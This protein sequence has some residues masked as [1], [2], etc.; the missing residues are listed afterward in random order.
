MISR[1]YW[2][3]RKQF[4]LRMVLCDVPLWSIPK[5]TVFGHPYGITI[6]DNTKMGENCKFRSNVTIG[7]KHQDDNGAVIG[8]N[9]NFGAGCIVLGP[10]KIGDNVTIAAGAIVTNNI[11]SNTIFLNRLFTE[12]RTTQGSRDP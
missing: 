8:N 11:P 9:V 5:S 10:V 2:C 4:P 6:A 12:L 1:I 3:L 7:Q